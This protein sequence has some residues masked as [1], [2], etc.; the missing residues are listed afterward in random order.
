M[1][2]KIIISAAA[3]A[4]LLS[5]GCSS[6]PS[7]ISIVSPNVNLTGE[8]TAIERQI[9]GDYMELE[10]DA[11]TLSSIKTTTGNKNIS[12][13]ISGDPELFRFI[14]IRE[15]H[16]DKIKEYK[17]EG[18]IGEAG[19]GY[20]KYMETK[21]YEASPAEK[22]I[23]LTVIDE[24]NTARS[25]IFSRSLFLSR[26]GEPAK[27]EIDSFGRAFAEEQR[28]LASKDEWIQENSGNWG[29]KK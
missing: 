12:G 2:K 22:K 14:K 21:K 19:T 16:Y 4:A 24:E 6:S 28:G 5:T 26:G 8:K 27:S 23:L 3:A 9:V 11:W 20:I 13:R 10:K 1:Y 25:G 17:S 29:R 7:C 15:F 18:A